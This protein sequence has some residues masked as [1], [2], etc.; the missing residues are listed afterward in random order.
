MN[1]IKSEFQ[2]T[3]FLWKA[4]ADKDGLAPVYIRSKQNSEKQISYNTGDKIH[5]LQWNK[6]KKRGE[7]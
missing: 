1:L 7:K 5:P 2:I 3:Y 6:K 4:R